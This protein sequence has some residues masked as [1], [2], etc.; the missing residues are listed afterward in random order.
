[1]VMFT[2]MVMLSLIGYRLSYVCSTKGCAYDSM[3]ELFSVVQMLLS[4]TAVPGQIPLPDFAKVR[5]T[6]H[7]ASRCNMQS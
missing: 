4:E 5:L 2:I 6:E 1:M 7:L 3:L